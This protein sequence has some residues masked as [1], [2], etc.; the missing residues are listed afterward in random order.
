MPSQGWGPLETLG[1]SRTSL[2]GPLVAVDATGN[3]TV[4]WIAPDC[5]TGSAALWTSRSSLPVR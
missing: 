5:S 4:L 2:Y 1:G 3:A